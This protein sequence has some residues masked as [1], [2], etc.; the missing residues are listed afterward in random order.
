MKA[1]KDKIQEWLDKG[2][3]IT[4]LPYYGPKNETVYFGKISNKTK[5]RSA[6]K[7]RLR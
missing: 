7:G 2:N 4:K 5:R 3:K 1:E 6:S